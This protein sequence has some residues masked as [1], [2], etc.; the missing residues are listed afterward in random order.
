MEEKIL[1]KVY[2]ILNEIYPK[3]YNDFFI[4]K[5][6]KHMEKFDKIFEEIEAIYNEKEKYNLKWAYKNAQESFNKAFF[7]IIDKNI[8]PE[9]SKYK[10]K[11]QDE[12]ILRLKNINFKMKEKL[13]RRFEIFSIA[14]SFVSFIDV[15]FS[16]FLI[17]I[18]SKLTNQGK[19][20]I[21]SATLSFLFIAFMAFSKVTINKFV[22][23]PK[24]KKLGWNI[25]KKS[26]EKYKKLLAILFS[27]LIS[28]EDSISKDMGKEEIKLILKK[29]I[30][31]KYKNLKQF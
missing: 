22:I 25:Y 9:I 21:S 6:K 10:D 19:N 24:V 14:S 29:V 3:H 1:D 11:I 8:K 30:S 20:V 31:L 15:I 26:V 28:I 12:Q 4:S 17:L 7:D 18:I 23:S 27:V 16:M 5:Q 2:K 13:K